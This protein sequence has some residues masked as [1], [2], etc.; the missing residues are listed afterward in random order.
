[1]A[2]R[3]KAVGP[4]FIGKWT[5][6]ALFSLNEKPHRHGQL[7]RRLGSVSQRMLTRNLRHLEPTSLIARSVR[8][9]N[10]SVVDYSLT[11]LGRTLIVP[12]RPAERYLPVGKTTS[13]GHKR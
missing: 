7:R 6:N 4:I 9:P 11:P 2:E 3:S 12:Y 5:V 13:Q 10:S 1:M 8:G